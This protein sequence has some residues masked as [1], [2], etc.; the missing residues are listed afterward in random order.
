M[1]RTVILL[2]ILMF[3]LAGCASVQTDLSREQIVAAYEDAGYEVWS[4]EYD[5][6]LDH[7]EIAYAQANH[8]DGGY[9][10]FSFFETEEAAKS[11]KEE[12]YHPAA[13]GLFSVIYGQPS[14]PQWKVCGCVVV[15]Y[16]DPDL[17]APFQLLQNG[18]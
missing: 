8:P 14:W 7:G 6:K 11:Y 12:Y 3:L 13:M 18:E 10:Y 2:L 16:D 4:R 5:E 9:I 1:K 17:L 15:Q